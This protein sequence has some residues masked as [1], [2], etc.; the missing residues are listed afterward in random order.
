MER[1]EI[2][3]RNIAIGIAILILYPITVGVAL[4]VFNPRPEQA[5]F[6]MSTEKPLKKGEVTE[7]NID[8]YNAA[9]DQYRTVLFYVFAFAGLISIAVGGFITIP[10]IGLG[11]ILGG[12]VSL[13][14]AYVS[15]WNMLKKGLQL[16]SLLVALVVLVFA[17]YWQSRKRE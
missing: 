13:I 9:V 4:D 5:D 17:A 3:V 1:I 15:Y 16:I 7:I 6:T 10:F 8:S 12:S 2:M 14:I 11:F